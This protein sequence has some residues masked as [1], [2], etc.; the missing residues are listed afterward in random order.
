MNIKNNVL[1]YKKE[2]RQFCNLRFIFGISYSFMIP[3]IPL[4]FDSLGISTVIIGTVMS[5]YGV[6]KALAQIPFG[7]VSDAIGDKLLL[8]IALTLMAF[9]PF[10]YSFAHTQMLASGIY[11]VQGAILGMAAPA[12]FS[13]LSR[14]LDEKKRGECTGLA[15][16]VFTLG[17]G[18]G[19]AVGGFIVSKFN[20]YN[21]VFYIA[22][23]GIFLSSV[24]ATL[25]IKKSSEAT[26]KNKTI[27]DP[28]KV[29]RK[30]KAIFQDIKK[31]KLGCKIVLL[32]AIAFLGDFIFG[33]IVSVF[34]FYGQEVLGASIRYTS[35]IISLYLFVFGFGAP[36]GGWVSDKIG[37]NKQLFIS[38]MVMSAALLGLYF[39]RGLVIFTGI[40]IIYFLGA[41]FLNAA[42]QSLLSEFGD[43]DNIKGIVFGFVGD[44]EAF[45]YALGPI[46][47]AYIYGLN[48]SWLFLS[49]LIVSISV[50][51]IYLLLCK[52][53][54]IT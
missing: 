15:S 2:L 42:L 46:V 22:S 29:K 18:I 45:G 7:M 20:N 19:A 47:S 5:L 44:S 1:F 38:F 35:G 10:S 52:K 17:G 51:V 28:I 11:V 13:I 3:I 14:S 39:V 40:I 25:R 32:G 24:F 27:K 8:I 37:N 54:C 9:V 26:S 23:I 30:T 41:T 4:F 48:K 50:L 6:S 53:T 21:M 43:N 36:I 31:Y 49:L 34:P 16:A 33:C 12:T